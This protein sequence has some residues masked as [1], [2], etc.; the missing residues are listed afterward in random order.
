MDEIVPAEKKPLMAALFIGLIL[1]IALVMLNAPPPP[2]RPARVAG[3]AQVTLRVA[4]GNSIVQMFANPGSGNDAFADFRDGTRCTKL[5]GPVQRRFSGDI[6]I[7]YY[8]LD[9]N[10]RIGYVNVKWIQE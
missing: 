2:S 6:T 9:C 1:F 5:G 8:H 4:P 3:T 10:G 7:D